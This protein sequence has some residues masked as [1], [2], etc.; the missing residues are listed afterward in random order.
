MKSANRPATHLH[1]SYATKD[2]NRLLGETKR[3]L[4]VCGVQAP[5]HELTID[6]ANVTCPQCEA[7]A[8]AAGVPIEMTSQPPTGG[9]T[10]KTKAT[11]QSGKPERPRPRTSQK[12]RGPDPLL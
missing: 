3:G 9:R 5:R 6:T 12:A 4:A 11:G 8:K 7:K 2:G 10:L 1:W